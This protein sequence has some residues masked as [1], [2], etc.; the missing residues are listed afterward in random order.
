[1]ERKVEQ[2]GVPMV[3]ALA[4]AFIIA[5]SFWGASVLNHERAA[6]PAGSTVVTNR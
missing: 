6:G 1:M 4:A 2:M 5:Y 3:V